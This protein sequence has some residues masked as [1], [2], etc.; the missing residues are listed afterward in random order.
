VPSRRAILRIAKTGADDCSIQLYDQWPGANIVPLRQA[1][2][3][4]SAL[5]AGQPSVLTLRDNLQIPNVPVS[6]QALGEQLYAFLGADITDAWQALGTP[7]DVLR[8]FV[9]ATEEYADLPWEYLMRPDEEMLPDLL[10]LNPAHR[11]MR[12]HE[13]GAEKP[14]SDRIVRVLVVT[15]A[16]FL[17]NQNRAYPAEVEIGHTGRALQTGDRAVH[18]EVL[19]IPKTVD[20]LLARIRELSPHVL[21]VVSHGAEAA[22][23]FG[24]NFWDALSIRT[25]MQGL[26]HKPRLVVL[27]ACYSSQ[28]WKGS[29]SVAR[30]FARSGVPAV[31]A[32]QA[33][34]V[35]ENALEFTREFYTRI[36]ACDPVDEAV[37]Q[38]R[39]A[40]ANR[41]RLKG[42]QKR[43]W[44]IPT[45]SVGLEP[46][47]V[48]PIP[49]YVEIVRRCEIRKEVMVTW[50]P[51]V[52]RE[53]DRRSLLQS[54][55]RFGN[56]TEPSRG[57]LIRG[58]DEIGKSWLTK[59]IMGEFAQLG[60]EPRY[61]ELASDKEAG[62]RDILLRIRDG[63]PEGPKSLAFAAAPGDFSS[64]NTFDAEFELKYRASGFK[65][66]PQSDID[67]LF[68]K[69]LTTLDERGRAAGAPELILV[70]DRFTR[71]G[72]GFPPSDFRSVLLPKL[73]QPILDG[74]VAKTSFIAVMSEQ[75]LQPYGVADAQGNVLI[76]KLRV[77]PLKYLE[78]S[79]AP[80]L[81][82][83]FCRYER[84][85]SLE[86]LCQIW[87]E[88]E[89]Q[90]R[91]SW[92]P[93]QFRGPFADSVRAILRKMAK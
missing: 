62:Y 17:D 69:F 45:L 71:Q 31:V 11:L 4:R 91:S 46:E 21:H 74:S 89:L 24:G 51:F 16:E 44:G 15:G 22:L 41:E 23:Q 19:R 65:G 47:D 48:L 7:N 25:N 10:A 12:Y 1:T 33:P 64:F 18:V 90:G 29:A 86:A 13:G 70:F 20:A 72:S 5:D 67:H 63:W 68:T 52:G 82:L 57:V 79:E 53:S 38:A 83:E 85:K 66:I 77:I 39:L 56:D 59:R 37:R 9:H 35:I 78:E 54:L 26:K 84:T 58:A 32:N 27:N 28:P 55:T 36:A 8:T 80:H 88:E 87:F 76:D 43:D 49:D 81:L 3:K 34:V 30:A 93:T 6:A 40:I 42:L 75:H 14:G 50:G 61:I 2:R 92:S 60:H 73:L